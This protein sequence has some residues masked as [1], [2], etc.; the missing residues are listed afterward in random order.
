M[1]GRPPIG[2]LVWHAVDVR[3]D[4]YRYTDAGTEVDGRTLPLI[5]Q[6]SMSCAIPAAWA[7]R[8]ARAQRWLDANR[9]NKPR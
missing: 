7:M 3:G 2:Y 8:A 6:L 4:V 9:S 5:A 1:W